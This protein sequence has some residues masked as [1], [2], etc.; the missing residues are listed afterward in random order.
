MRGS[1][2]T[3]EEA[4][5]TLGI[6]VKSLYAYVSR[7]NIRTHPI[8]GSRTRSYWAEDILRLAAGAR[9]IGAE[10]RLVPTSQI[11]RLTRAGPIY[12]G[13]S[14]LEMAETETLE[15]TAA[16]LWQADTDRLFEIAPA[17]MPASFGVA[18][19]AVAHLTA[20]EQAISLFPLIEHQ[21]L[22]SYDLSDAGFGRNGADILR[23]FVALMLGRDVPP[24]E[25][26]HEALTSLSDVTRPFA[27]L[28]RR[29]LVLAADHELSPAT[30]AVRAAANTGVTAWQ[31][32][33]VGL[34]AS[35]GRRLT[36]GRT[37]LVRRLVAEIV[38]AADPATLILQRFRD[39]EA[40]P[41]FGDGV[42]T[43]IDPRAEAVMQQLSDQFGDLVPVRR[44][45]V[46]LEAARD[47][48]GLRPDFIVPLA[49]VEGELDLDRSDGSLAVLGRL[50]GFIAHAAEQYAGG[51]ML[52]VRTA[53]AGADHLSGT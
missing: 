27:D 31:A 13:R 28:V 32:V 43:G 44:L 7:K 21:S 33:S 6:S 10:F 45:R 11:T 1:Y 53:Y 24:I 17:Q 9:D 42:Y 34:I 18:R 26:I 49:M 15:S 25:P 46:A 30:Y 36:G 5:A 12:R 39:D 50:A 14:A 22:R 48:Y 8:E 4:A 52:R 41:G 16:H 29:V 19:K 35:Q 20:A 2:M 3:A 37:F 23:W 40:L 51:E 47:I 38:A